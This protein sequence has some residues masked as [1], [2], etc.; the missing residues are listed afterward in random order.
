MVIKLKN[1]EIYNATHALIEMSQK[2]LPIKAAFAINKT[3]DKMKAAYK[4]IDELR[5]KELHLHGKKDEDG[6]LVTGEGGA[7]EFITPDDQDAFAA[8]WQE[9]LEEETEVRV[10]QTTLDAFG[11]TQV[12]PALLDAFSFL[13][14]DGDD[15]EATG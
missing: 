8:K 12:T 6:K 4:V 11:D 7:V 5:Q 15:D 13:F 14:K 1:S 2:P 9:L 3:L 10:H